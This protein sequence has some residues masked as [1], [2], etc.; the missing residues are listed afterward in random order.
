MSTDSISSAINAS[1]LDSQIGYAVL[2]KQRSAAKQQG[3]AAV[4]LIESAAKV[5][6]ETAASPANGLDIKA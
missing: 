5:Q 1:K 2:N 4:A 3:E 6:A